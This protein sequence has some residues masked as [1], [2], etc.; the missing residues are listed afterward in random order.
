M[1]F[2]NQKKEIAGKGNWVDEINQQSCPSELSVMH[3]TSLNT[4]NVS[5]RV[6][7]EKWTEER[8]LSKKI[9]FLSDLDL[10][11]V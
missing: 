5:V 9:T 3:K 1:L 4:R 10:L 8:S 11:M 2:L 6:L 7:S